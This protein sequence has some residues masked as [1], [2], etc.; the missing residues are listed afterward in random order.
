MQAGTLEIV[1]ETLVDRL[2]HHARIPIGF[3]VESVFDVHETQVGAFELVER[4]IPTPYVKD[5]DALEHPTLWPH[6]FDLTD[7]GLI[8]AYH[9][10]LRVAGAVVA[11]KAPRIDL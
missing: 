8:A 10:G 4:P 1:E 5:N 2:K 7:W 9:Q 11:F 6:R 3:T